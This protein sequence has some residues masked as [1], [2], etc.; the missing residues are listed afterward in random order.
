MEATVIELK[1][2][3]RTQKRRK[4]KLQARL[5]EMMNDAELRLLR[6]EEFFTLLCYLVQRKLPVRLCPDI[7]RLVL[8]GI[9][10][11]LDAEQAA[12]D[13]FAER[14]AQIIADAWREQHS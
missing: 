6:N 1:D 13:D 12:S 7:E 11:V 14:L 3:R 10:A 5:E 9:F 2:C 4:Q 8:S